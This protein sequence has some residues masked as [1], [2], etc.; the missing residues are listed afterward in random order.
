MTLKKSKL[1]DHGA[2][3]NAM[4]ITG[5]GSISGEEIDGD[6]NPKEVMFANIYG[7]IALSGLPKGCKL[8]QYDNEDCSEQI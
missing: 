7:I 2:Q 8:G 1:V 5:G 4:R 3:K 6:L